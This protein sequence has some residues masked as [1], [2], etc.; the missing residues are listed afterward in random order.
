[1]A[2]H[3]PLPSLLKPFGILLPAM[4]RDSYFCPPRPGPPCSFQVLRNFRRGTQVNPRTIPAVF[5][6]FAGIGTNSSAR[7][8]G[9]NYTQTNLVSNVPGLALT[10]D[11]DLLHPWGMAV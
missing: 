2:P 8:Q 4:C 3:E 11:I 5:L 10:V 6:L 7:A 9:N 1:M